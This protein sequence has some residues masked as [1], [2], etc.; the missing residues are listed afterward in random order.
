MFLKGLNENAVGRFPDLAKIYREEAVT[1]GV[2]HDLA[3]CQMLVETDCLTFSNGQHADHN[4]FGGIGV[5]KGGLDSAAFPSVRLGVRAHIQ[6]LKAYGS[7]EPLVL[8]AVDPRFAYVRRGVAPY[9]DQLSGRWSA[10][11]DYGEKILALVRRL[12]ES[13][14]L[15]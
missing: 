7:Q 2:N 6:H 14:G 11:M 8:K 4:N 5:P 10:G 15:L 3:F 13:A 1:E 9:I 12:Y